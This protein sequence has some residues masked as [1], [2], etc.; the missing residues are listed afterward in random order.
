MEDGGW[1]GGEGDG[2]YDMVWLW[3]YDMVMT[4]VICSYLRGTFGHITKS[5]HGHFH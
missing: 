2:V 4:E 5:I 1:G 3:I